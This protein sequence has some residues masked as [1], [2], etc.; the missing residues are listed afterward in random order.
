MICSIPSQPGMLLMEIM[1]RKSFI[2]VKSYIPKAKKLAENTFQQ[3]KIGGK[4]APIK[5]AKFCGNSAKCSEY[6]DKIAH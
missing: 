6:C 5:T 4:N 3:R 2:K 1:M